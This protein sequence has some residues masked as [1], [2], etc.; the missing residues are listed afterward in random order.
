M[1]MDIGYMKGKEIIKRLNLTILL[2]AIQ[3]IYFILFFYKN[4]SGFSFSLKD[5][6]SALFSFITLLAISS[7]VEIIIIEQI[8]ALV[9]IPLLIIATVALYSYRLHTGYSV[10]FSLIKDNI[11]ISFSPEAFSTISSPFSAADFILAII[12]VLVAL[13]LELRFKVFSAKITKSYK[14]IIAAIVVLVIAFAIPFDS[15]D[16]FTLLIKSI[17]KNQNNLYASVHTNKEFPYEKQSV[18]QTS[19]SQNIPSLKKRPNIILILIESFNANFTEKKAPDGIDYTPFFNSLINKGLYIERFYGNSI[20]TCKG[21]AAVFFSILPSFNGK[22]FVD[23]SDL[24]IKGFPSLLAENGYETIFFQAYHN[25]KFD[26]TE[27]NMRK[28]GFNIVKTFAEFKRKEDRPYIW[29]WG[30]EDRVFYERFFEFLDSYIKKNPGKPFF[31]ALPTVGTHIPCDGLP[32]ERREIYKNPENIKEKYSNA[33]RLSDRHLEVFFKLLKERAY[34]DNT[35]I[36]ITSDHSFPMKEHGIYNN[37]VCFYDEAF[38]IPLL[39]LWE[40]VISPKRIRG[41]VCSQV[42]IGPTIADIAGVT[43]KHNMIGISIFDSK[44][45]AI[46]YLIQPYNGKFLQT[47]DYPYKYI[48]HLKTG[49]EYLFN[50]EKDPLE[51][52]NLINANE[53]SAIKEKLQGSLEAI[54]TNQKLIE[55][56]KIISK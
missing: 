1:M 38:R 24:N 21:Q 41:R 22:I 37:E 3:G 51:T 6:I 4:I 28:A 34:L 29:G 26:N 33:L 43:G 18:A 7:I 35:V 19:F 13:L 23:Y 25:L 49:K 47:V 48:K 54:Y 10:D 31:A 14:K 30:V 36:I 45:P 56:N 50:L 16:E 39:I 8:L 52:S 53:Y 9:I 40:G 32:M 42:D 12:F 46:V 20:Q 5:L 17:F 2:F 55:E 15:G 11:G 27:H 44:T